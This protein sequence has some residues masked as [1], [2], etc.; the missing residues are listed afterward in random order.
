MRRELLSALAASTLLSGWVL[1]NP[2]PKTGGGVVVAPA[3]RTAS[4]SSIEP[5]ASSPSVSSFKSV[6]IFS[7]HSSDQLAAAAL[8][9]TWPSL[10]MEAADR[11]PFVPPAPPPPRQA[12]SAPPVAA[13]PPPPLPAVTYRFWGSLATPTGER[14]LYVARDDNG[15]PIAVQVGTRL[16]GGFQVEQITAGAIVLVQAESQRHVTLSLSPLPSVGMH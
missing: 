6:A 2:G 9:S 10:N 4:P 14:V 13:P 15:Q 12:A 16:D 5:A 1:L 8:P 7:G 11:S 3:E